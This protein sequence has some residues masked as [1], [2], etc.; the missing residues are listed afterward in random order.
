M[1][2]FVSIVARVLAGQPV[3]QGISRA[4]VRVSENIVVII[5]QRAD[6][7]DHGVLQYLE[8]RFPTSIPA[9]CALGLITVGRLSFMFITIV[10]GVS[11]ESRWPS[12]SME[13][14][15]RIRRTLD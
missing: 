9:P 5:A 4:I 13:A 8:E 14:K 12:M 11:L 10:P 3:W 6:H 7:D 15:A 2:P 1:Q